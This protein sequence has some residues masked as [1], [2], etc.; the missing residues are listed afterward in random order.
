MKRLIL[1]V[2]TGLMVLFC[3]AGVHAVIYWSDSFEWA[4]STGS[5]DSKLINASCSL[6]SSANRAW[7]GSKSLRVAD[8]NTTT[9]Q[10]SY[11]IKNFS[12]G[13]TDLYLRF[14]ILHPSTYTASGMKFYVNLF[15]GSR[16][17][18]ISGFVS[19][20]YSPYQSGDVDWTGLGWQGSPGI[21]GQWNCVEV[22]VPAPT[23]STVCEIWFNGVPGTTTSPRSTFT[24]NF[25]D[26]SGTWD[27]LNFGFLGDD[28][29]NKADTSETYLDD[30]IV[31]SVYIGTGTPSVDVTSPTAPAAVRD[32]TGATDASTSYSTSSISAN[33]DDATDAQTGIAKYWYAIGTTAGATDVTAWTDNLTAKTVTK[34]GTYTIGQAYYFTVKAINGQGLEGPAANSNGQ[35][36]AADTTAPGA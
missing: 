22:H 3:S 4:N 27:K 15:S 8:T 16:V 17:Y 20:A 10:N 5:W 23:A 35:T 14:Y 25:A 32:S 29:L 13:L 34:S 31:S 2:G 9:N 28:Y 24:D 6:T 33:W 11:L 1:A 12:P 18:Y 30:L 21:L 19:S 7:E 36:I 26:G